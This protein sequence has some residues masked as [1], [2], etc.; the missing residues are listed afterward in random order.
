MCQVNSA[1][2]LNHAMSKRKR[3]SGLTERT[4][5]DKEDA[6]CWANLLRSAPENEHNRITWHWSVYKEFQQNDKFRRLYTFGRYFTEHTFQL[7][8][9]NAEN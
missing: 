3:S 4:K 2:I 6:D 7:Q 9:R 1:S 5:K 8:H